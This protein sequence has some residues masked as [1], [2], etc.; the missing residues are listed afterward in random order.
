MDITINSRTKL[1]YRG[2][3]SKNECLN[4]KELKPEFTGTIRQCIRE[5]Q[6]LM[7]GSG[8]LDTF[9]QLYYK[10]KPIF[11]YY[12]PNGLS[13]IHNFSDILFVILNEGSARIMVESD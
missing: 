13:T 3:N 11:G 8:S 1:G 12:E 9:H 6:R 10:N 4:L 5:K 2:T 7:R